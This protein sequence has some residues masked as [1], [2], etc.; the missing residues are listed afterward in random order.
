M[1]EDTRAEGPEQG[2]R[3]DASPSGGTKAHE[4]AQK[5]RVISVAEFFSRNRHLLGFDNP[6]K[7]LLTTVKEAVDNSL[8]A[9][10][11]AD[12]L[13]DVTVEIFDLQ[14]N[15]FRVAIEDNG[16]GILKTQIAKVFGKLLYGSK[17]Y[18]LSQSRGQQG[19]GISAAVLYGQLTTSRPIKVLSKI[20]EKSPATYMELTI[21]TIKNEAKVHRQEEREWEKPHG[22]RIEIDLEG[23]YQKGARSVEE[24]LLHTAIV[25]PH[26]TFIYAAPDG[27]QTEYIRVTDKLPVKPVDIKPHL[28]GVE[29]D[30]LMKMLES[31][32]ARTLQGFLMT[33]FSRVGSKT[34]KEIC[35]NSALLPDT[36][37][38]RFMRE[39]GE[40]LMQGIR[41]SHLM[42]PPTNCLSP[43]GEELLQ[44][45]LRKEINAEFFCAVSRPAAVYRGNPF[46]IEVGIAYGGDQKAEE[47]VTLLRFAN[48][49]PLIYQQGACAINEAM[50]SVNWKQY[51]LGQSGSSVPSGPCTILVH[52]AS[53]WVPFTSESKEAVAHYPE[54][55]TEMRL[56]LQEAGRKLQAYVHHRQHIAHE[57]DKRS[58]IEK[59][60][61]HVGL[62]LKEML[63]LDDRLVQGIEVALAKLLEKQRGMIKTAPD[64]NL[65][66][67]EGLSL[68]KLRE[69]EEGEVI[70]ED[71]EEEEGAKKA[72]P[73]G[74][75]KAQPKKGKK[76]ASG[77]GG[78][79]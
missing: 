22:T 20:S 17:F 55:I 21:D 76:K 41:K 14:N 5:Q 79:A 16:P 34:A 6:R 52:I 42:N 74:K 18:K 40:K 48:R 60:I 31:T 61:P 67:E 29:L 7:A 68:T 58:Y 72:V 50:T 11:E 27:K 39:M 56:A 46:Q 70:E 30:R 65:M 47:G 75:P 71:G 43:I 35:E 33:E 3:L 66:F 62:A 9:C 54:I 53:V 73:K 37:P 1:A 64:E 63:K 36:K 28:H 26:A 24:Y 13:P 77:G 45:G 25:N 15:L 23:L 51:G 4:M 2:A 57:L 38:N 59:Y 78:E 44:M 8:D 69:E 32:K 49:V 10:E 12:I 19:I